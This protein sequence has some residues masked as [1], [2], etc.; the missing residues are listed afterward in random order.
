MFLNTFPIVKSKY[1][2]IKIYCNLW[3]WGIRYSNL[4]CLMGHTITNYKVIGY[5][6][7]DRQKVGKK[8][9]GVEVLNKKVLTKDFI[10][11]YEIHEII[12]A[13]H[14]IPANNLRKLVEGLVDFNVNVKIVPPVEDWIN[15][16]FKAAQIK[17]CTD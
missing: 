8:I 15:G 4:Q 17:K 11:K 5:V 7:D 2:I 16:E 12:V 3:S 10:N 9:N 6:D 1:S 13:I 14:N